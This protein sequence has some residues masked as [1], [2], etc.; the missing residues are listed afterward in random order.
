MCGRVFVA[1]AA[2]RWKQE[3][4]K[5]PRFCDRGHRGKESVC[6]FVAAAARRWRSVRVRGPSGSDRDTRQIGVRQGSVRGLSGVCQGSVRADRDSRLLRWS[7][8]FRIRSMRRDRLRS[9]ASFRLRR[10]RCLPTAPF[11]QATQRLADGALVDAAVPRTQ[12]RCNLF[13]NTN[14]LPVHLQ[15]R[16]RQ[17]KLRGHHLQHLAQRGH[18]PHRPDNVA[19]ADAF[20]QPCRVQFVVNLRTETLIAECIATRKTSLL[21]HRIFPVHQ[22]LDIRAVRQ[23]LR[24]EC[25]APPTATAS[26]YPPARPM[27]SHRHTYGNCSTDNDSDARYVPLG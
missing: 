25:P 19:A 16:H 5:S 1:A 7:D 20:V 13:R 6:V 9:A 4:E 27:R 11:A 17:T 18:A 10:N 23:P 15:G 2:R 14:A 3:K 22:R 26:A 12:V 8:F 21:Q 24:L